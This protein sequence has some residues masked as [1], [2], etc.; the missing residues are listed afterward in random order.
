MPS[1]LTLLL[2]VTFALAALLAHDLTA[3][4]LAWL[5]AV[6]YALGA[7]SIRVALRLPLGAGADPLWV[8]A[9]PLTALR[10]DAGLQVLGALLGAASSLV[11]WRNSRTTRGRA[12]GLLALA[13]AAAIIVTVLPLLAHAGWMHPVAAAV[14]L[15]AGLGVIG[16]GL[17]FAA[18]R[19]SR[20][21]GAGPEPGSVYPRTAPR[22]RNTLLGLGL[23]LAVA[24]PHVHLVV[25]GAIVAAVA[26][27]AIARPTGI[28]RIPVFPAVATGALGFV[29]YYLGVI[30]GPTGLSLAALPEAPLSTAAQAYLV[31]ALAVGAVGFFGYWPL[32][33]LT[34]GTWLAPVGAAL[35]LRLGAE[36]LPLGMEGWRTITI[37]VGVIGA[38]AAALSRRPLALASSGA[39]LACFAAPGGGAAAAWLLAL[40]PVLGVRLGDGT[41]EAFA[42]R[43]S[44]LLDGALVAVAT[45]GGTLAL[46]ALLRVE[47]V[48]AVLAAAAAAFS[49]VYI[50]RAPT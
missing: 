20:A 21:G 7:A 33:A 5:A 25:A 43:R 16:M 19:L 12:G 13:G 15:G 8:S 38:W 29:A 46:D 41:V 26:A 11:A 31:P 42:E 39:W 45:L 32:T 37:P 1:L 36:S 40:V 23:V 3:R 6:V 47:V 4:R 48:Y 35:L 22:G 14:A 30:A 28:G 24:A 49:A 27:Y 17:I 50:S 10:I 18:T 2:P 44:S 9:L 34:P